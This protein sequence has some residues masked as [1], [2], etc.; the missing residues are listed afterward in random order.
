MK[1]TIILCLL[2]LGSI[3]NASAQGFRYGVNAGVNLSH[4]TSN[5]ATVDGVKAGAMV[6]LRGEYDFK[7]NSEGAY[8]SAC[9]D[10]S[11]KGHRSA[12]FWN[13]GDTPNSYTTGKTTLNYI[14]IPVHAGYKLP[15]SSS[16]SLLG[17]VGP[18]FSYAA[19]GKSVIEKNGKEVKT[20]SKIFDNNGFKRFDMGIGLQVGM[21]VADHYQLL[22]GYERGL[23]RQNKNEKSNIPATGDLSYR[24]SSF[25]VAIGFLF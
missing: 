12:K 10:W 4:P 3:A 13:S 11:Q 8:L 17:E 16:V 22:L 21:Q 5:F 25:C 18:Y 23:V 15:I 19:W 14:T 2:L 1:K 20:S 6:G 24:N 7:S 9:I